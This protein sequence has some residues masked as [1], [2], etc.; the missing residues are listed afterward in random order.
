LTTP[1]LLDT[2]AFRDFNLPN[3]DL[4]QRKSILAAWIIKVFDDKG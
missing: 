2:H 3:P 4:D 1:P